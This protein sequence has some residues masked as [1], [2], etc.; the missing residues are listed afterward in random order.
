MSSFWKNKLSWQVFFCCMTATFTTD[1]L[2]SS[3][4]GFKY[5]NDFGLFKTKFTSKDLVAVNVIA[6]L[7]AVLMG[8][9][10]GVLGSAF[11]HTNI[12]MSKWRKTFMASIKNK[13]HAN[14]F[15]VLEPILIL[16][17]MSTIHVYLP[18]MLGMRS[19]RNEYFPQCYYK[20]RKKCN[21]GKYQVLSPN[22]FN[23][24]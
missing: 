1:L 19:I 4:H 18:S 8:L 9:G 23:F 15:R 20:I 2:N 7:P 14:F 6:V 16:S 11:T 3:F 10:G 13:C 5:K 24:F 21:L 17:I 12:I 22:V